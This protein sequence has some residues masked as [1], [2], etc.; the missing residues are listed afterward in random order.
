M[1]PPKR[2]RATHEILPP[3]EPPEHATTRSSLATFRN[4]REGSV[5][6]AIV[7]AALLPFAVA[8]H[9]P[10]RTAIAVCLIGAAI[11][12][13]GCH[14]ACR[15]RLATLAVVPEL[16][17]LPEIAAKSTRLLS[18]RN[19]RALASGLRRTAA[20][21]QPPRRFDTCPVLTDRVA[22]VRPELLQLADALEQN[23]DLD[24]AS[25]A[26]V[27]ELLTNACSPLYNANLPADDLQATISRARAGIY[28]RA[29]AR[30]RRP[31][32]PR[33]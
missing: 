30:P 15:H 1:P 21:T 32:T 10:D 28:L 5:A 14:I 17:Q 20:V 27:H 2:T 16:T 29:T 33:S 22:A 23:S 26:L 6:T 24:P 3:H 8:W 25:V 12:G 19:R 31:E 9:M 11:L 18:I 7:M 13:A 4:W